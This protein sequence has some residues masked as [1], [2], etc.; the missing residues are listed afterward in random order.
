MLL[1]F[2][3]LSRCSDEAKIKWSLLNF[4]SLKPSTV[5]KYVGRL[6]KVDVMFERS[7]SLI[8]KVNSSPRE[9]QRSIGSRH[10]EA[11]YVVP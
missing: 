1:E 2:S 5:G 11:A 8:I 4:K 9:V 10:S 7:R 6:F 3:N